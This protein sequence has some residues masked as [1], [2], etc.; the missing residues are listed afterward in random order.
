M[1]RERLNAGRPL[2]EDASDVTGRTV[3][4]H[5]RR[6]STRPQGRQVVRALDHPMHV[7]PG[8][9][10]SCSGT[11]APE[12]CVVKVAGYER[13][14]FRAGSGVRIAKRTRW[15][16]SR[17]RSIKAWHVV[18]IRYEGPAGGPGMREMLAVT[19][20]GRGTGRRADCALLTDGRFSGG[21]RGLMRRARRTR[22]VN[23]GPIVIVG[24]G[25]EVSSTS[26]PAA[27][28]SS[29]RTRRSRPAPRTTGLRS[30]PRRRSPWPSTPGWSRARR[31]VVTDS[32]LLGA[33][34]HQGFVQ[35]PPAG[36][37]DEMSLAE[38]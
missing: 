28:T 2:H 36:R 3:G 21:T 6:A 14:A 29:F 1:L 38:V 15:R 18:V 13:D 34:I 23:G 20:A 19:G 26:T 35:A 16:R 7:T 30:G 37:R 11:L 25:D 10:R 31:C 5:A 24:D 12:G 8:G 9:W 33:V 22:A 32:P 17:P 4:E 27:S